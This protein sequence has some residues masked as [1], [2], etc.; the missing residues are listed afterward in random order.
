MKTPKFQAKCVTLS[1]TWDYLQIKMQRSCRSSTS[2]S[3]AS[4]RTT[5]RTTPSSRRSIDWYQKMHLSEN[6]LEMHRNHWGCPVPHRLNWMLNSI[7]TENRLRPI[8]LNLRPTASKFKNWWLKT[9]HWVIKCV[10]LKK[11]SDFQQVPSEN[12]PINSR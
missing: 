7:S 2:T 4:S 10:A 11:T 1:K 8:M 3:S 5:R 12:W 9:M 6:K